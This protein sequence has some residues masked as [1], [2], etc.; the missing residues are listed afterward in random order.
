[1]TSKSKVLWEP[2][3]QE[4]KAKH[5]V[6]PLPSFQ[7]C[8]Q[9]SFCLL[10]ADT[11]KT[12]R[13]H[14]IWLQYIP[15]LQERWHIEW[16]GFGLANIFLEARKSSRSPQQL[17]TTRSDILCWFP[18]KSIPISC[19]TYKY[20]VPKNKKQSQTRIIV[21]LSQK[22]TLEVIMT[23]VNTK[24]PTKLKTDVCCDVCDCVHNIEG[25][26]CDKDAIKIT[27]QGTKEAHFCKS[28]EKMCNCHKEK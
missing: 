11:N 2:K 12:L 27:K 1:M 7:F 3:A 20:F 17:E 9:T 14:D 19:P 6:L 18:S 21:W 5:S 10:G 4:P 22:I 8:S 25:C 28:Y 26:L 23:K 15:L 24:A 13:C 16:Q